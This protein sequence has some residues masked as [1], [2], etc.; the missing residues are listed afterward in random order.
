MNYLK[1]KIA[2]VNPDKDV[3][4]A[5]LE[6][7][8][9]EENKWNDNY[10]PTLDPEFIAAEKETISFVDGYIL[11]D[12]LKAFVFTSDGYINLTYTEKVGRSMITIDHDKDDFIA[13]MSALHN[14]Y[15]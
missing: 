13:T 14:C 2:G 10:D 3:E 1:T 12:D 6:I 11:L 5:K 8:L 9:R 15:H 7:D 4:L